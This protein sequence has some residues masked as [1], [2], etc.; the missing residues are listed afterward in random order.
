MGIT[1]HQPPY[2]KSVIT[3]LGGLRLLMHCIHATLLSVVARIMFHEELLRRFFIYSVER[4]ST[5]AFAPSIWQYS[6]V[7]GCKF[8]EQIQSL[9][10]S[11]WTSRH[12]TAHMKTDN[13]SPRPPDHDNH[14]NNTLFLYRTWEWLDTRSL[15]SIICYGKKNGLS[16]KNDAFI[17]STYILWTNLISP[18]V[19]EVIL[20]FVNAKMG[21]FCTPFNNIRIYF[22]NSHQSTEQKLQAP[23]PFPPFWSLGQ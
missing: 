11:K 12:K 22:I 23:T 8:K 9:A 1:F 20:D 14:R 10:S 5:E 18:M 2:F 3:V 4:N 19:V 6:D 16:A 21:H 17:T 13:I 7:N 15:R